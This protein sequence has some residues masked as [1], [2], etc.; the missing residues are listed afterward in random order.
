MAIRYLALLAGGV[1]RS[2]GLVEGGVRLRCA[3]RGGGG[4]RS[5]GLL[6]GLAS[7]T[8]GVILWEE[9]GDFGWML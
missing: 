2:L 9:G 7:G 6:V 1:A 3:C 5:M 8:G 4:E